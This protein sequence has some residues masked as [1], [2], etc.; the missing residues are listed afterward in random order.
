MRWP[1]CTDDLSEAWEM[2][3]VPGFEQRRDPRETAERQFCAL[4]YSKPKHQIATAKAF[5]TCIIAA[6]GAAPPSFPHSSFPEG[7]STRHV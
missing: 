7:W 5:Y 4:I 3:P 1:A 6:P 2:K